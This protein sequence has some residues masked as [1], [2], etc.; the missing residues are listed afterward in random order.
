M[1]RNV[2]GLRFGVTL[3]PQSEV[4]GQRPESVFSCLLFWFVGFGVE[5]LGFLKPSD[6]NPSLAARRNL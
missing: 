3:S 1:L 5:G 6:M 4:S 2:S